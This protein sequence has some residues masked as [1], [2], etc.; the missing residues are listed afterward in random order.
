M[1]VL[2]CF[3]ISTI[4]NIKIQAGKPLSEI[5]T[6]NSAASWKIC[7]RFVPG[8]VHYQEPWWECENVGDEP[9]GGR[10]EEIRGWRCW[11]DKSFPTRLKQTSHTI[12]HLSSK[13]DF[14][15]FPAPAPLQPR[16]E[17]SSQVA[18]SSDYHQTVFRE[19]CTRDEILHLVSDLRPPR[20]PAQPRLQLGRNLNLN[21]RR[22]KKRW[23]WFPLIWDFVYLPP[24]TVTQGGGEE[25][26]GKQGGVETREWRTWSQYCRWLRY[27]FGKQKS[28]SSW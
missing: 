4:S 14:W 23:R 18:R 21:R 12:C 1:C 10:G 3:K 15:C 11:N 7:D 5:M 17:S 26:R 8:C 16:R 19:I 27:S 9:K 6:I 24:L 13:S 22:R 25:G 28:T 20:V 2:C